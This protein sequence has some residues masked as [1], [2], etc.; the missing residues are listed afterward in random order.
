MEVT[1]SVRFSPSMTKIGQMRSSVVSTFSRTSRRAHSDLRLRRGRWVRPSPS[2]G[3]ASA[4]DGNGAILALGSDEGMGKSL[5]KS[6]FP[7]S[8][9]PDR[10]CAQG[11]RRRRKPQY[12]ADGELRRAPAC[13][14]SARP[15]PASSQIDEVVRDIRKLCPSR[16]PLAVLDLGSGTG[17]FTPALAEA[18]GGPVY[19]V[20]PSQKMRAVAESSTA[21]AAVAYLD[22]R[23]ESIPLPAMSIDLVLMHLSFHHVRDRG[24]AAAEIARV[25]RADGRVLLRSTFSDRLPDLEWMR[26]FPRVREIEMQMFPS[27]RDVTRLFAAVGLQAIALVAIEEQ[28]SSSLAE[29]AARLRMRAISTFE[30][31]PEE[32]IAEGFARLDA[33]VAEK[34]SPGSYSAKRSACA[35]QAG[36]LAGF[37]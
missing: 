30:H 27:S 19:G 37:P 5:N 1:G 35:R 9:V 20:E 15:A 25:L 17:R 13:A 14:I 8:L 28:L 33:A 16:R 31:M 2:A 34:N 18:F 32:K 24:A 26:N 7:T 3:G 6:A 11:E 12:V 10:P 4:R 21:H 23:A 29:Y 36:P 22:G